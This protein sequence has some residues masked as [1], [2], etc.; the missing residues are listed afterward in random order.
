M[1]H[2]ERDEALKVAGVSG[3]AKIKGN[4]KELNV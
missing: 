1:K 2:I 4:F 3:K